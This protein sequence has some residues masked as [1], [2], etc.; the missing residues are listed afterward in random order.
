MSSSTRHTLR[1]LLSAIVVLAAGLF[2]V[3]LAT[4]GLVQAPAPEPMAG[5]TTVRAAVPPAATPPAKAHIRLI[6]SYGDGVEKH[7]T[8]VAHTPGMTAADAL[9]AAKAHPRGIKLELSGKGATAFVI[10]IDELKNEGMGGAKKN[11]QFFINDRFGDRGA[12]AVELKPDD[13]VKWVFDIYKAK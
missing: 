12:G 4:R 13:V 3:A 9:L 10:A 6:I 7:F 2:V 5:I 8:S 1:N 11:W